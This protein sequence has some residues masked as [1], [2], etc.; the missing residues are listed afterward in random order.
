MPNMAQKR[1]EDASYRNVRL[2]IE[3]YDKLQKY[4]LNLMQDKGTPWLTLDD[5]VNNLLEKARGGK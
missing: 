5:A 4:L 1:K 3:T 2:K